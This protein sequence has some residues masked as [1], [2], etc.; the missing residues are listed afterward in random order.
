VRLFH[1][2]E[3]RTVPYASSVNTLRAMQPVV[4]ASW[5]A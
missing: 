3:D 5:S 2:Q 1:G 4:W